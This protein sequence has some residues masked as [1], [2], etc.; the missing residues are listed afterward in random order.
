MRKIKITSGKMLALDAV[1]V[2]VLLFLD[3]FTK[4]LAITHLKGQP[5]I[6]LIKDVLELQYLENRGSAFSLLQGQ[7]FVILFLGFVVLGI[8]LYSLVRIPQDKKFR[9]LHIL[10][11][12]LIAGALGNIIDRVRFDYVVDFISFILIHFPVFNVADCYIVVCTI[13]LF[14]LFMFIYQEDD[15]KFLFGK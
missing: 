3:Q 5:P 8:L 13:C 9:I 1:I 14:L 11:S 2:A 15:L 4:Y 6:V 7:K 10:L 12:A